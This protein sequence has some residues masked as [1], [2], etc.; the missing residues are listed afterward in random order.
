MPPPSPVDH[1]RLHCGEDVSDADA[2]IPAQ[3]PDPASSS[4]SPPPPPPPSS[5]PFPLPSD[6]DADT[7]V[8]GLIGSET[9]HMPRPDYLRRCR[10]RSIDVTTRQDSINWILRVHAHYR[11][12]PITAFLSVNY[13][14]RFLSFHS[15]PR[16]TN[17]W[18]FQLLSVACLSLAAKM[19][20]PDVPLLL[21]LQ[22]FD[23]KFVFEPRTVQRMELWVMSSLD[24]RLR[25]VTPFD[26]L[27]SFVPKLPSLSSPSSPCRVLSTSSD[28]IVSTARVIDFLGFT[29]STIAAAA[30]L[31]A[32]GEGGGDEPRSCTTAWTG[33]W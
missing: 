4:S 10:D 16:E 32:A 15:L 24:W 26:F 18:A 2:W 7:V 27:P 19:E 9:H 20:E 33:K 3:S 13:L 23:P 14:D 8:L 25:S 1:H 30:V 21:D 29:P 11:F 6:D 22:A 17:G 31:C 28:L 5:D 12:R